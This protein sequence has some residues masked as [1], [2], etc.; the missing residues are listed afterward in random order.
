MPHKGMGSHQS[1]GKGE[2]IWLTPPDIIKDLGPFDLDPCFSDPRPWDTAAYHFS[3][4]SADGFGGLF[5]AWFGFVWCN[6]PYDQEA[7]KWL[8]KLADHGSGIALVFARTE[9]E[10]FHKQVWRRADMLL[11]LEGRLHFMRPNGRRSKLNAGAP[12]V[13]V[14]YGE[15]ACERLQ[16]SSIKGQIIDMRR[17]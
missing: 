13:L 11:F 15:E 2:K 7:E 12:S 9:T 17:Q 10:A 16:R 5:A 6:P 1:A 4:N 3:E 14:G 8:E